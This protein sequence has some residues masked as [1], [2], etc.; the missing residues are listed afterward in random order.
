ML[1][2]FEVKIRVRPA[3]FQTGFRFAGLLVKLP[4]IHNEHKM[5][6]FVYYTL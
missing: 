6:V 3:E 4:P 5:R 2:L 1:V